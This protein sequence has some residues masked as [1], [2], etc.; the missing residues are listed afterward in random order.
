VRIEPSVHHP[1]RHLGTRFLVLLRENFRF[2]RGCK[3]LG[4]QI[5]Y[6]TPATCPREI[7]INKHKAPETQAQ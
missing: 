3:L 1:R 4:S 2:N 6:E 5:R 7:A